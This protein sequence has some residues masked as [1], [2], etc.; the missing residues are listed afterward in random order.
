MAAPIHPRGLL[1]GAIALIR[2]KAHEPV[3]DPKY[4]DDLLLNYLQEQMRDLLQDLYSSADTPPWA[5]FT[6]TPTVGK[7]LYM[8]PP[9]IQELVIVR[10]I[11]TTTGLEKWRYC[12][13]DRR[14]FFGPGV[15]LEG[16]RFLRVI[17]YPLDT[18]AFQI[19]YIPEM[20]PMHHSRKNS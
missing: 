19:E 11:D 1:A 9:N 6:I 18:E 8:L 15:Q 5:T 7:S 14:S 10:A 2:R 12:P 17:P 3:L 20:V 4:S 16:T 13:K